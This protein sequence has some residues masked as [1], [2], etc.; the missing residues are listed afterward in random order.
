MRREFPTKVKLAAFDR[1]AGNCE[2][3]TAPLRPGK[4]AFDHRI[5]DAIGGEPTLANCQ[6]LCDA[7]HSPKTRHSDV[8]TIAKSKR[9]RAKHAGAKIKSGG[10]KGW[11]RFDGTPVRGER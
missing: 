1:A 6:V 2:A 9:V 4:Y 5:P 10:F 11:R 8:P 3:C 7:C